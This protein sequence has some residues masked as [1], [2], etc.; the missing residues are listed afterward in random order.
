MNQFKFYPREGFDSIAAL[1]PIERANKFLP[2]WFKKIGRG[3]LVGTLLDNEDVQTIRRCPAIIDYLSSGYILQSYSDMVFNRHEDHVHWNIGVVNANIGLHPNQ[4]IQQHSPK[5]TKGVP[6]NTAP[7]GEALK[8]INPFYMRL[9]EGWSMLFLDPYYH[10]RGDGMKFLPAIVELD[11]RWQVNFPFEFVNDNM[12]FT[13]E[14]GTPLLH[15]IPFK[16]EKEPKLVSKEFSEEELAFE[17]AQNTY[18][19]AVF[20]KDYKDITDKLEIPEG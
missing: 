2:E 4:L 17:V 9:P 16:R 11:K 1:F 14:A 12:D 15:M 8:L 6:L 7:T 10:F 20:N 3:D 18:A 5:Q 19:H 13:I